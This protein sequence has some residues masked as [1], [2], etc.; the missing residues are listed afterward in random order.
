MMKKVLASFGVL[1]LMGGLAIGAQRVNSSTA[2]PIGI[3]EGE[4]EHS[5]ETVEALTKGAPVIVVGEVTGSIAKPYENLPFTEA[6]LKVTQVVKG[7]V[8]VGS[9]INVLETGGMWVGK[10]KGDSAAKAQPREVTFEGIPIMRVGEK[11]ILFLE[12]YTGPITSNAFVT[13]GVYQGKMKVGA[14]GAVQFTGRKDQLDESMF[15]A[16]Q[17]V[18][19]QAVAAVIADIQRNL[20]GGGTEASATYMPKAPS[21]ASGRNVSGSNSQVSLSPGA[22]GAADIVAKLESKGLM[23]KATGEKIK[24]LF[25]ANSAEVLIAEGITIQAYVFADAASADKAFQSAT[26]PQAHTIEWSAE[27]HFAKL[28]NLLITVVTDDKATADKITGA[29]Q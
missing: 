2:A 23:A 28:G 5:Y 7:S 24:E 9:T 6:T 16:H 13:L 15:A 18:N 19:G 25:G 17:A 10:A 3:F 11:Y 12:P 8:N 29:L 21:A 26:N 1:A 20:K 14:N 4:L 22:F 27:P